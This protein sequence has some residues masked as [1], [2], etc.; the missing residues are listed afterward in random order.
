MISMN[1]LKSQICSCVAVNE[2]TERFHQKDFYLCF[3][4]EQSLTGLERHITASSLSNDR[5]FLFG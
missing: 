1:F 2:R 4:D 5:I 3:E